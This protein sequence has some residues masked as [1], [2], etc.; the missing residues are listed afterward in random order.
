MKRFFLFFLVAI[1]F[2]GLGFGVAKLTDDKDANDTYL[3]G[4]RAAQE[5]L[6]QTN[7]LQ[8]MEDGFEITSVVGIITEVRNGKVTIKINPIEPLGDPDLDIREIKIDVN[9]EFYSIEE[10]EENVYQKE[11][12]EFNNKFKEEQIGPESDIIQPLR[13][14]NKKINS[15]DLSIG[16]KILVDSSENIRFRKEFTATRI[17]VYAF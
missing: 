1:I 14:H 4:W 8:Q 3:N 16:H 13:V 10:K 7:F 15:S 5:R 2:L 11:M 6:K 9:T 17:V 12:E